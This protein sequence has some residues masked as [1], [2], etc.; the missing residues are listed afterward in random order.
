M[1]FEEYRKLFI[2]DIINDAS[3]EGLDPESFFIERVLTDLEDIGVLNDPIPMSVEILNTR[4]Q[5]LAFDGYSYDEADGALVLIASEFTNQR[6]SAPTLTNTRIEELLSNMQRFIEEAVNDN[7][8]L[9]CDN[10]D[11][12]VNIASE[13]R[14]K[15]GKGTTATEI[16]RFKF[17]IISNYTLSI[18]VKNLKRPDLLGRPVE[19]DVWTL[20]RF[21][22]VL[23]SDSDVIELDTK[24]FGCAGIQSM[25]ANISGERNVFLCV[26]PG[27]LIADI[28]LKYGTKILQNHIR[29]FER[30]ISKSNKA[31]RQTILSN[32]IRL[33]ELNKGIVAIAQ[34]V[35]LNQ[36]NS[37]V[38]LKNFQIID[39]CQTV[40][41][42]ASSYFK[43]EVKNNLTDL[44]LPMK[45]I[46]M[47]VSDYKTEYQN[48]KY[49][50][51]ASVLSETTHTQLSVRSTDFCS[52]H[53]FHIL[54]EKLSKRVFAPSVNGNPHQTI[55]FYERSRRRWEQE[56]L[57]MTYV[58]KERFCKKCPK[59]Q[60]VSKEK[61]ARCYN[62]ILMRPDQVC[63]SLADNFRLFFPYV[64]GLYTNHRDEIN[65]DFYKK[66]V[67]SVI[68]FD[69]LN[70][71]VRSA[72]WYQEMGNRPQIIPYTISKLMYLIPAGKDIDWKL[73]WKRQ[74]LYPELEEEL[75][76]I[77]LIAD[78]FLK[79]KAGRRLV[80]TTARLT[81]TWDEL[82]KIP[83][84][85]N[86]KFFNTLISK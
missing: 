83:Y 80:R 28:Y 33:F 27:K 71:L 82:K 9:Y 23:S 44:F 4:R 79:E 24:E 68:L 40:V 60:V 61:F 72:S 15:I 25:Q 58:Q 2:D 35:K 13:F 5:I 39:G 34:D 73:I 8:S 76:K 77:A 19:L 38:A 70:E 85:L 29:G 41:L 20:E 75:Q 31:I 1:E 62:A 37:I 47:D 50:E 11:P 30:V 84:E 48:D 7:I 53:P 43:H 56:Q 52:N 74:T 81:S 64:D 46:V 63:R 18:N 17:I 78:N 21:Y 12:A 26:V 65:E 16:L 45:L 57:M 66:C 6:D 69:S 55:W 36:D 51:F 49:S 67:C 32:P 14:K 86:E 10:S 59:E 42:L 54:M 3:L 22:Q